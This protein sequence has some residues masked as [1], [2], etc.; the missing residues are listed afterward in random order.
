[1]PATVVTIGASVGDRVRPGDALVVVEA[2]KM[3]HL[4]EASAAG[5]VDE[6]LVVPGDTVT[7][8][9]ILVVLSTAD[10]AAAEAVTVAALDLDHHRPDL[11]EVVHR[12][13]LTQDEARP[14]AVA[15]RRRTGQRTAR[16]NLDDLCD[17]GSFVEYGSLA[18][19]ASG[20]GAAS[21]I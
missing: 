9:Q 19:A 8:G 1:M 12:Q 21:T 2:M 20:P 15:R 6:V 5:E 7:T 14:A 17:P 18:I 4:I 3:E 13:R 10:V 11:A 16:E